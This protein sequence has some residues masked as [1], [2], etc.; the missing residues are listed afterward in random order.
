MTRK[1]LLALAAL[2][3]LATAANAQTL[4]A[5][6]AKPKLKAEVVVTGGIVRIGDLVENAG[7]IADVPIFRSPDLGSTGSVSAEAV[8]EAVRAH[9]LIGLD[10]AGLNDVM[11]TRAARTIEPQQIE[12]ALTS[13]LSLQYSLGAVKDIQL[14]YDRALGSIYVEPT[15]KGEPRVVQLTYDGR[16]LR[17]D[18]TIEVPGRGSMRLAGTARATIEVLTVARPLTRGEVI[19]QADV[20]SERRPRNVVSGDVIVN[21]DLAIGLAVRNGM[22]PGQVL[23]SADLTKPEVVV[24][25][26]TVTLIYQV[27]G[28]MLTVRGKASEGGAEGDVIMVLNEQSKR[29][30]QGVVIGPGRVLVSTLN[31]QLAANLAPAPAATATKP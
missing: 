22:Q 12:S 21:R 15:A 25:N 24:R 18:A 6:D 27:P 8:V 3:T 13:A 11:V 1:L 5:L 2:G 4:A 14:T 19:K 16:N 28:I 31:G 9:A 7:I 23:R 17:F 30:V 26:E 10:T 20:V 29:L